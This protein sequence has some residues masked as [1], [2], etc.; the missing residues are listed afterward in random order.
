MKISLS[1]QGNRAGRSS[2]TFLF[3]SILFSVIGAGC[4]ADMLD[5]VDDILDEGTRCRTNCAGRS[6]SGS[7]N[8]RT[9][10]VAG[11]DSSDNT[12]QGSV[13]STQAPV[14]ESSDDVETRTQPCEN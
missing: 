1:N 5:I 2:A 7:A 10:G 6:S 11:E 8:T 12:S 3:S 4:T 13:D 14:E 9:G